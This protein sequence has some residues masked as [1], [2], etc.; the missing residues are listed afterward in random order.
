MYSDK[1]ICLHHRVHDPPLPHDLPCDIAMGSMHFIG[2][3]IAE[4]ALG[5]AF[6]QHKTTRQPQ[7][8][9]EHPLRNNRF[10]RSAG[11]A[12]PGVCT[13]TAEGINLI[14]AGSTIIAGVRGAVINVLR[15]IITSPSGITFTL[16]TS[17]KF[18]YALTLTATCSVI[19]LNRI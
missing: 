17:S 3:T 9:H 2:I 13:C 12:H 18:F 4:Y 14:S 5:A 8:N 10:T 7:T 11:R 16:C 1:K 15:T 6:T 19:A